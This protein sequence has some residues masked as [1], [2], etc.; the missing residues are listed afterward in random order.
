MTSS[1]RFDRSVTRAPIA[2]H[3]VRA[4]NGENLRSLKT[5]ARAIALS[6]GQ[7]ALLL[8]RCNY[9]SLQGAMLDQLRELLPGEV[10]ELCLPKSTQ[11][12]HAAIAAKVDAVKPSVLAIGGL[13][14]VAHLDDLL[15]LTNRERD[16]FPKSFPFPIVLWVT[17]P[18]LNKLIRF[19]PDFKSWAATSIKFSLPTAKLVELL[20]RSTDYLFVKVLKAGEGKFLH[21]AALDLANG[22]RHRFEL[23]AAVRDIQG[24][25]QF[26]DPALQASVDFV[27]G[28]DDYA[29]DRLDSA[30]ARYQ[31]SLAFWQ[32]VAAEMEGDAEAAQLTDS[33]QVAISRSQTVRPASPSCL[34]LVGSEEGLPSPIE[35][36]GVLLFHMGLCYNRYAELQPARDRHYWQQAQQSFQR[37]L[38]VFDSIHRKSLVARFIGYL[39]ETLSLLGQWDE[40][41]HLAQQAM[42]LHQAEGSAAQLAQDYGFLA[43]VALA[44]S[45][46]QT[47]SELA[48]E[49]LRLLAPV[50]LP[51]RQRHYYHLLLLKARSQQHLGQ[52]NEAAKTLEQA[53]AENK[54]SQDPLF[55][56]QLLRVLQ[57]VYFQQGQYRPAF[58]MKQARY[59]VEYQYGYR[60]FIG[61]ASLKPQ[62][63]AINP[64]LETGGNARLVAQ[65]IAVS[66]RQQDIDNLVKRISRTDSTLTVIHGESGVGKSSIIQ[67]GLVPTLQ[68]R[69]IGDR[70]TLPVVVRY[71]NDWERTL[72]EALA[73]SLRTV[74]TDTFPPLLDSSDAI[75][76]QLQA[77]TSCNRLTVLIFEQFEAFFFVHTT[78]AA[79]RSFYEFLNTCLNLPFVNV[80]LSLRNDYLFYL[81]EFERLMKPEAI[82]NNILDRDIRYYLGKFSKDEARRVIQSLTE[83][84]KVNLE[85]PLI[86][87][88]VEDLADETEEIH[89]IEL[90]IV[91]EQLQ[92]NRIS[93]LVAYQQQ[94]SKEQLV[95][96][97]LE[98][99][100]GDCGPCHETVARRVLKALTDEDETRPLKTQSELANEASTDRETLGLVLEV[101]IGSGFVYLVPEVPADR[102]Q[103]MQDYLIPHIRQ[104]QSYASAK[105]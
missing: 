83:H 13:G 102:Y 10:L 69:T 48:H 82:S 31:A 75:I 44:R 8:V 59:A 53:L 58:R 15:T 49:G 99:V 41:E 100:I 105:N 80:I 43:E 57:S 74:R 61:A 2:P 89:P 26:L 78:R 1:V 17:D 45:Q 25:E 36:Q 66:G 94:G 98:S 52:L 103:L 20:E 90:Q 12:L 50:A 51:A 71:Y 95:E 11:T 91:G 19:A 22:C 92:N 55:Y 9:E 65:E 14:A 39:G 21:N 70:I 35:R 24:R 42:A 88:L 101:L 18:V 29:V 84:S 40:L 79:R 67:A 96:Q 23:E 81:L 72:G 63:Q 87:R 93:T 16:Q 6:S 3:E 97:F 54:P 27:L 64:A 60:A 5:L 76:A 77:N 68:Q 7:F 34:R 73:E 32:E 104:W 46:W 47:A 62:C 38:E 85:P 28:R 33:K 30:L 56:I 4:V 86:D 37:C